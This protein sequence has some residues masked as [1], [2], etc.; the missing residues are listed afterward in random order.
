MRYGVEEQD[1]TKSGRVITQNIVPYHISA[2][3]QI[4]D[5]P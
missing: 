4:P 5:D 3:Y 2:R 1:S